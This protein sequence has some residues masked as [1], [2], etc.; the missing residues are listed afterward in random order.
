MKLSIVKKKKNR[1]TF[2]IA[3]SSIGYVNSLRR[4]FMNDVPTMAISTVE[5]KQNTS[6]LYDESIA[7]RLGL[8]VLKTDLKSYN[9]PKEGAEESA[10]THLHLT[11]KESGPK[12]VYAGDLKS[13][14]SKVVPVFP[15][16]PIVKLMETQDIELIATAH[17]G[18]GRN[19]SKW[20]PGIVTYYFK[21]IIKVNNKS[22]KLKEFI[23]KYPPKIVKKGT[24]DESKINSPELI[25]ACKGVCDDVVSITYPEEQTEFIFTIECWGQLS[26]KE[27]I[28]EG[29]KQYDRYLDEFNKLLKDL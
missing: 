11:L 6:A 2:E 22:P 10:A 13:K 27:I 16:T 9:I 8:I 4:I 3:K 7:H 17:L 20:T 14:D 26:P 23:D 1:I 29:L 21:P 18:F 24:I 19:H 15:E 28:E 25:D 5:F 12:T